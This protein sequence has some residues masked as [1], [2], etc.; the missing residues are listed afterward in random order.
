[1]K[2]DIR[3]EIDVPEGVQVKLDGSLHVKG[4]KGE[5]VR[6]LSDPFV[7][8]AVDK[9]K[10]VLTS[11]QATKREKKK[12]YTFVAHI[13]NMLKGVKKGF[14]YEM[15][16]CAAH[17]PI[18]AAVVGKELVIKNFLGEVAPRKLQ[19]HAGVTVKV[20]GDIVRIESIDKELA[21]MTASDIELI[22][23]IRNRDR[24]VFQDGIFIVR[25]GVVE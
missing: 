15:K 19:L 6:Q 12:L 14:Y 7:S 22:T 11:T 20:N 4:P 23:R 5:I 16:I 3:E 18:N 25:K 24:R 13:N 8:L 2:T 10:I 1:M 17:F 21:G 9:E